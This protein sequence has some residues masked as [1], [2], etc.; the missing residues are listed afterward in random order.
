MNSKH[1]VLIVDDLADLRSLVRI[2]LEGSGFRVA[3]ADSGAE[4]LDL[5]DGGEAFALI[6]SDQDMPGMKGTEFYRTVCARWPA[7][8]RRFIFI[9][10]S[11]ISD[12]SGPDCPL[13]EKPFSPDQLIETVSRQLEYAASA[14]HAGA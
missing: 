1:R 7:M 12:P 2:Y 4:A 3:E 5:L 11:S 6:L 9:S 14:S 10:G 8:S 13:V